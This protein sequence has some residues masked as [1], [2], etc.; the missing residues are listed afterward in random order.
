MSFKAVLV[1]D[2][3]EIDIISF[4]VLFNQGAS[5]NGRPS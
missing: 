4:N 3:E 5:V 1:V 2:E